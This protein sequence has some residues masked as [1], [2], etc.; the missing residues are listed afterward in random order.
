MADSPAERARR[1]RAHGRGD[2]SLC[3]PG[4]CPG[5]GPRL[6]VVDAEPPPRAG[7]LEHQLLV[8]ADTLPVSA[9]DPRL[10]LVKAALKLAAAID[11][12]CGRDLAPLTRELRILIG[13]MSEFEAQADEL[14][15]IQS[16]RA[17]RRVQML[18]ASV[19]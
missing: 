15:K 11:A 12:N 2:H 17:Q 19:P 14:E 7:E 8:Y 10:V 5:A 9:G 4:R 16:R 18:L 3:K 6:A 13:H 1:S